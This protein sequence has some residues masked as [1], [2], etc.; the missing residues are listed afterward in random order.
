MGRVWDDFLQAPAATRGHAVE[1][2]ADLD[3]LGD[4]VSEFLAVGFGQGEPALV[5]ATPEH[6][7]CFA[8]KLAERGWSTRR[9]EL[10]ERLVVA[11]ANVTRIAV[12]DGE[13]P[14]EA[15][16]ERVVGDLV[17][18]ALAS[19]AP[20][21]GVRVVGEVVDI[22]SKRGQTDAALALEELWNTLARTR[23]FSLLCGYQLD[24]FDREAQS[25][26]LP[27]IC[28]L[29]SHVL[30]AHDPDSLARAVQLALD[31]VVGRAKAG[32]IYYI[33]GNRFRDERLPIAQRVLMWLA[34]NMPDAADRVLATARSSYG[35]G[36]AVPR[37]DVSV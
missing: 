3:A 25:G 27:G 19:A 16:F 24:V 2:Y 11:D 13:L 30:P 10:E 15:A 26:P 14:S 32:D 35:S 33:V 9:L 8:G 5:I 17:D 20:E 7:S 12:M 36:Y 31:E 22:L 21:H 4:T 37:A 34:E 6:V 23:R 1:I 18:R 29:H 28:R